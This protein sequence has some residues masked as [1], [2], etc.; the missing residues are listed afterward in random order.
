[1]FFGLIST[2]SWRN[3]WPA[4]HLLRTESQ[5]SEVSIYIYMYIQ[6]PYRDYWLGPK[7]ELLG[8][9]II[10]NMICRFLN[11]FYANKND[12]CWSYDKHCLKQFCGWLQTTSNIEHKCH[13]MPSTFQHGAMGVGRADTTVGGGHLPRKMM[14]ESSVGMIF[15]SQLNGKNNMFETTNQDRY[16]T[17]RWNHQWHSLVTSWRPWFI[18]FAKKEQFPA[19]Y[20]G[21]DRQWP[22]TDDLGCYLTRL[23]NGQS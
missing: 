8:S 15:H 9:I 5:T 1:M 3:G 2:L 13:P 23:H 16:H 14:D 18:L 22:L 19:L 12:K 11:C 6:Y 4:L 7:M 20:W 17:F 10:Y 21:C